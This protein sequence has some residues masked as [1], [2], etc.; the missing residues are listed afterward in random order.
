M[1]VVRDRWRCP[2]RPVPSACLSPR[3]WY[4][5]AK[6][7]RSTPIAPNTQRINIGETMTD[8]VVTRFAPSPTGFLHIGGARTALF[9]EGL[10][11]DFGAEHSMCVSFCPTL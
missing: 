9:F 10:S 8:A 2:C 1:R 6:R 5:A 4:T 11:D 7:K 3:L